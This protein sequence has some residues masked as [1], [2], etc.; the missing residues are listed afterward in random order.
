L[1]HDRPDT[2][3]ALGGSDEFHGVGT[4]AVSIS[5]QPSAT[6]PDQKLNPSALEKTN[7]ERRHY[8]PLR[9]RELVTFR[10]PDPLFKEHDQP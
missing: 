3:C 4:R 1:R 5:H 2:T 9:R 8:L 6:P 10:N 7:L